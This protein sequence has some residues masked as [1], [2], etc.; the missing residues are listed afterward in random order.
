MGIYNAALETGFTHDLSPLDTEWASGSL[1]NATSLSYT[2]WNAWAKNDLGGPANTVNV[3]AVMHLISEN[4]YI[5]VTF[6]SWAVSGGGFSYQRSTAP[7]AATPPTVSITSPAAGGVF[8]APAT[9]PITATASSSSGTISSV[10]F[11]VNGSAIGASMTAPYSATASNLN[12]GVY[13]LSAVATDNNGLQATNSIQISVRVA[14]VNIILGSPAVVGGQ[15]QFAV[16]GLVVG[17][18]NFVQ[19]S[20]DLSSSGN[21][22]S[23]ATNVAAATNLNVNVLTAT[24]PL[25]RFFRVLQ[26]P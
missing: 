21:W 4:I 2:N 15:F 5:A 3:P 22:I 7:A 24:N 23:I 18:T 16:S 11:L 19:A 26:S 20:S 12:S 10:Q 17:K 25:F 14:G 6:T 13:T 8:V 9:F 1:N